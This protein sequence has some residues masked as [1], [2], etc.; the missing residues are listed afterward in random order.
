MP[1]VFLGVLNKFF[2]TRAIE[3][4]TCFNIC[5]PPVAS[6]TGGRVQQHFPTQLL[7]QLPVALIPV[8]AG[9]L[10]TVIGTDVVR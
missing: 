3:R 8:Q 6:D 9:T 5:C 4:L 2:N 10:N 7:A 1:Y